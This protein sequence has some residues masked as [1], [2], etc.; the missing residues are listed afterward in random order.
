MA[1]QVGPGGVLLVGFD[2]QEGPAARSTPAQRRANGPCD[3]LQRRTSFVRIQKSL[4]A[5]LDVDGFHYAF[6]NPPRAASRCTSWSLRDQSIRVGGQK[7]TFTPGE[8]IFTESAYKY[9]R[10][11]VRTLA[12]RA[13]GS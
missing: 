2:P 7:F 12:W 6:Y 5:D 10:A 9:T 4:D 11:E 13:A 3:S 8:S 1:E